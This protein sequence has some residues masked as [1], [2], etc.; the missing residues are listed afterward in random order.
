MIISKMVVMSKK[1]SL[2]SSDSWPA[3]FILGYYQEHKAGM[4]KLVSYWDFNGDT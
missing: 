4:Q 1:V 2:N 3:N